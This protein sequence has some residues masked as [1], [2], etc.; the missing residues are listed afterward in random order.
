[1]RGSV[2]TPFLLCLGSA[3]S[4]VL[5]GPVASQMGLS[6]DLCTCVFN[7]CL[8]AHGESRCQGCPAP[9]LLRLRDLG[10]SRDDQI[11]YVQVPLSSS[12]LQ[13]WIYQGTKD[14]NGSRPP[15]R[16]LP[17]IVFAILNS[18]LK[19]GSPHYLS[20]RPNALATSRQNPCLISQ[21]LVGVLFLHTDSSAPFVGNQ[22]PRENPTVRLSPRGA[23]PHACWG[24]ASSEE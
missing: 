17:D 18:F 1:M 2:W 13:R 7:T 4:W 8:A 10:T 23:H 6:G 9:A 15:R 12:Y 3:T 20:F 14:A 19:E 5:S 16:P 24:R 11:I 21:G 22:S